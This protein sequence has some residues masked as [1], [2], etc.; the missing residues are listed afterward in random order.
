MNKYGRRQFLQDSGLAVGLATALPTSSLLR[1]F[2]LAATKGVSHTSST[3]SSS[4]SVFTVNSLHPRVSE[5]I[6]ELIRDL[7]ELNYSVTTGHVFPGSGDTDH[8]IIVGVSDERNRSEL[9]RAGW[10]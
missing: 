10:E 3:S 8:R 2:A 6:R 1:P 9:Q 7:R 4:V 5:S